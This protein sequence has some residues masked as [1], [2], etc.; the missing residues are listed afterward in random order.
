[1]VETS[2]CCVR[3]RTERVDRCQCFRVFKAE[4]FISCLLKIVLWRRSSSSSRFYWTKDSAFA[5]ECMA[6][7]SAPTSP[8]GLI[9]RYSWCHF[10]VLFG[11]QK[12][13]IISSVVFV[14]SLFH[15]HN[16]RARFRA[17]R[18]YAVV[19]W[20]L[21]GPCWP[22]SPKT[23]HYFVLSTLSDLTF[24]LFFFLSLSSLSLLTPLF[25]FFSDRLE[26]SFYDIGFSRRPVV[27][28]LT[29]LLPFL[30]NIFSFFW[31]LI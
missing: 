12:S 15:P 20:P 18:T 30:L 9:A 29:C 17:T 25:K 24:S 16:T 23:R 31:I 13:Y 3:W 27:I 8:Q 2:V 5:I 11:K 22:L 14:P 7:Q 6:R 4:E 1:M 19:C 21:F 10:S 28:W 26:R